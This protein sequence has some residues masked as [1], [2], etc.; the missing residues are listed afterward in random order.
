M[1]QL[2]KP[3]LTIRN[4]AL[5]TVQLEKETVQWWVP[6]TAEM[7]LYPSQENW[8]RLTIHAIISFSRTFCYDSLK[9]LSSVSKCGR[10]CRIYSCYSSCTV[11]RDRSV[12]IA[13][14][15]GLDG[16]GIESRW[17][18][19]CWCITWPAGF[20]RLNTKNRLLYLKAKFVPRSKHFSS[21]L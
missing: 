11:G 6:V 7:K 4:E 9:T 21:R 1:R 13:T 20:K 17:M 12:G 19:N 2:I 16:P 3:W 18:L 5:I 14:R 15:Y 8:Y 10:L